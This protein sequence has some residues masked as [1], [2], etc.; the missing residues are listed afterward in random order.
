MVFSVVELV[1]F[2]YGFTYQIILSGIVLHW[3]L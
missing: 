2:G 1:Y 3:A